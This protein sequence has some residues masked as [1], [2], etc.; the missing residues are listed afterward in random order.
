MIRCFS[1]LLAPCA[2]LLLAGCGGS[3]SVADDAEKSGS[4]PPPPGDNAT[5]P[6]GAAPPPNSATN[7][8]PA[9]G[10]QAAAATTI[11]AALHGRWG[12]APGD[13]TSTRGDA[14]GLLTISAGEL[15]FYE[16]RAVPV[17]NV[18]ASANSIS[19]DFIFTGEG[20]EWRKYQALELQ[21][22]GLVRTESQPMASFTY[23]RCR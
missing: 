9:S 15:R 23:A 8:A 17:G 1:L 7:P 11:P 12:L 22:D 10:P 14:K 20:M 6:S 18:D 19:G 13:C 5:D 2:A 4:L 21:E 16:S 3:D